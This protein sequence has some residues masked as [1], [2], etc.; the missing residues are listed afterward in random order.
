MSKGSYEESARQIIEVLSNPNRTE[1]ERL[2]Y[3]ELYEETLE[4]YK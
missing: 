3:E 1:I 2:Q 4:L